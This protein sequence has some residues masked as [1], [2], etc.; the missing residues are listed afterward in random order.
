MP[1]VDLNKL[2]GGALLE[3]IDIELQR[4]AENIADPNTK[5]TAV[6]ELTVKIALKPDEGREVAISEL[7][8]KSKLAPAAGIPAK[9]IIDQDNNGRAVI[10]ELS[11]GVKNQM[12]LDND[13][14]LADDKGTKVPVDQSGKVVQFK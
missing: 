12:M 8:V 3:R 2:A 10:A 1:K 4:M 5:A 6:R 14:D 7:T 9:F 11:S 13:G